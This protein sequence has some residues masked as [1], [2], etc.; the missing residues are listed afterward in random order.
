MSKT[1]NILQRDESV[2]YLCERDPNLCKLIKV[3]GDLSIT[4]KQNYF[5][6]LVKQVIGQQLSIKAARTIFGRVKT[7]CETIEPKTLES[8]NDEQLRACGVSYKKIAYIR[9]LSRQILEGKIDLYSL[10]NQTSETIIKELTNI[11]GIGR[12][13][14]EMFLI[15]SLGKENV[16]SYGDI[17][18]KRAINWLYQDSKNIDK[19]VEKWAPYKTVA[20]LYLWEIV[21]RNYINEFEDIDSLYNFN[22]NEKEL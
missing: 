11:K 9:D 14:V 8:I 6:A 17:G 19:M 3:V 13:T 5:E 20:S 7:L 4:L 15:F 1:I 2:A 22:I 12:W 16:F 10:V 18:L 21:N